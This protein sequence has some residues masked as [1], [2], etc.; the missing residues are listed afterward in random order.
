NE[1]AHEVDSERHYPPESL[2]PWATST[3]FSALDD[4]P[5]YE[6]GEDDAGVACPGISRGGCDS[7]KGVGARGFEPPTSWSRT[8]RPHPA[9]TL[10]LLSASCNTT[11][12]T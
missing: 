12:L 10:A 3:G 6:G 2:W 8:K 11:T 1:V 7:L 5:V 4:C 9:F